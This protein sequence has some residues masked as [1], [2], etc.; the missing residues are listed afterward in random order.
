MILWFC[1]VSP[2]FPIL[3]DGLRPSAG[4]MMCRRT[5]MPAPH[6]KPWE[7]RG[8]FMCVRIGKTIA[9]LCTY[10]SVDRSI[11]LFIH[12]SIH[13]FIYLSTYLIKSI[14]L[15]VCLSVCPSATHCSFLLSFFFYSIPFQSIP[16]DSIL[17]GSILFY[18]FY[19]NLI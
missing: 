14:Y 9:Q 3:Q 17:F 13:P 16:L 1:Q 5:G 2:C 8:V 7:L 12:P 18:L 10:Q 4:H 11:H 15:S 19:L 6:D